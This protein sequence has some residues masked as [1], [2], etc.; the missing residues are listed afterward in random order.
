MGK[1]LADRAA[2]MAGRVGR[3][4]GRVARVGGKS[5]A[6]SSSE[7][8][9]RVARLPTRI[10]ADGRGD[11]AVTAEGMFGLARLTVHEAELDIGVGETT[12]PSTSSTNLAAGSSKSGGGRRRSRL[13]C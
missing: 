13:A 5:R 4:V 9:V 1:G 7:R 2:E 8:V 11:R 10:Y 6:A 3:L 12:D